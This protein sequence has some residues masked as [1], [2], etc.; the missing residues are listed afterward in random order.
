MSGDDVACDE[1]RKLEIQHANAKDL[2]SHKDELARAAQ[3]SKAEQEA[4]LE[5]LKVQRSTEA[6]LTK[7]FH[8]TITEVST[9][10]IDRSRDSAKFVQTAASAIFALYT[11]LLALAFSVTDNPLPVRGVWA[12]VFLGLSIALSSAYLAFLT[13]A[14]RLRLSLPGQSL[15][16][17]QHARSAFLT[18]WTNATVRNRR[19]A[20]RASVVSLAFGAAFMAAPFVSAGARVPVPEAP[21]APAIPGGVAEAVS[22]EA[23][24]LFRLQVDDYEAAINARAAALAAV[25]RDAEARRDREA[26]LEQFVLV[27]AAIGMVVALGGPVVYERLRRDDPQI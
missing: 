9:T 21:V 10:A 26:D 12:G 18:R 5:L 19:W 11:G 27:L 2:E 20:I 22:A 3:R 23:A 13:K 6:E 14:P 17:L 25:Q 16:Q 24:R 15:T 8:Q 7:L 1:C 4:N